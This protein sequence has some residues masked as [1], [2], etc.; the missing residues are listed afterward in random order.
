MYVKLNE[1]S[2][3]FRFWTFLNQMKNK[4]YENTASGPFG[5]TNYVYISTP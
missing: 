5:E 2:E 1:P 3:K 4:G